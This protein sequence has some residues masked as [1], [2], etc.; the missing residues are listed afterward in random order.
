MQS[1]ANSR[2]SDFSFE[3]KSFMTPE[4]KRGSMTEFWGKPEVTSTFSELIPS[5][6]TVCVRPVKNALIQALMLPCFNFASRRLWGTLSS[7][8][9]PLP[10]IRKSKRLRLQNFQEIFLILCQEPNLSYVSKA[11]YK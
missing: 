2:T 9:V 10:E 1:S 6:T 4:N 8:E 3:G 7:L 5:R 11:L